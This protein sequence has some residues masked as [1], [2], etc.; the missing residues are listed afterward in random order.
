MVPAAPP[1]AGRRWGLAAAAVGRC[2]SPGLGLRGPGCRSTGTVEAP[3]EEG[4]LGL[5]PT[6][7]SR[8]SQPYLGA[9]Y[10]CDFSV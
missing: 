9:T 10:R 3:A 6:S 2:G 5:Q 8:D 1:L 7:W 4:A